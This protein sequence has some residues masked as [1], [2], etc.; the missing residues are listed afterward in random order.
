MNQGRSPFIGSPAAGMICAIS[1][2]RRAAMSD[3]L[4]RLHRRV[5]SSHRQ[6]SKSGIKTPQHQLELIEKRLKMAETDYQQWLKEK[7]DERAT[8]K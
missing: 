4:S 7:E 3:S 5:G 6:K 1:R 2:T 8:E